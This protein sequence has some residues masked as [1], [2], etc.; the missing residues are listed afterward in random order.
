MSKRGD[1]LYLEDIKES[2]KKIE[3]YTKGMSFAVF[4]R[5]MRTIDAV[6]RNISVIGEAVKNISKE[7]K[8]KNPEISWRE[9]I[10]MRN[11][12]IHEYFGIDEEILWKTIKEDIPIFKK[13]IFKI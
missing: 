4:A 6:V 10:G 5:D 8:S 13:Q 3:K 7:T 2:I 11:K 9:I 1:K 12:V